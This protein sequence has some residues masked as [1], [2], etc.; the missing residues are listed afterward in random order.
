[1]LHSRQ[2]FGII[3][4]GPQK[5]ACGPSPLSGERLRC[6]E[7]M[8]RVRELLAIPETAAG[9]MQHPYWNMSVE[10]ECRSLMILA[11]YNNEIAGPVLFLNCDREIMGRKN[12]RKSRERNVYA[13]EQDDHHETQGRIPQSRLASPPHQPI[14]E[15]PEKQRQRRGEQRA[16]EHSK[17][18]RGEVED[19]AQ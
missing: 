2:L 19:M 16:T 17:C 1:M 8:W 10:V 6:L 5:N 12:W 13:C 7:H 14:Q 4:I 11:V 15:R 18:L 3:L 9:L